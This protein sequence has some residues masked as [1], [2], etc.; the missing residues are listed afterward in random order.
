MDQEFS[1]GTWI[2]KRRTILGLSREAVAGQ[3]GYSIAMLR[4]IE[5]DERRPSEKAAALLAKALAIPPEQVDGFLKVA[6]QEAAIDHLERPVAEEPFPWQSVSKPRTNLPLPPTLFVGREKELANLNDLLQDPSCRLVTL[7]GLAGIGKTRLAIQAAHSQRAHFE[8]GVFFVSLSPLTSP[9]MIAA[10]ISNAMGLELHGSA[11]PEEH[12]LVNLQEKHILLVLDNFEHL[13]DGSGLLSKIVLEALHTRILVTSRERLNL[14]GEWIFDVPGLPYPASPEETRLEHVQAYESVQLFLQSATRVHP[15]FTL[16]ETNWKDVI[17]ICK[18]MEGMP[19]GI[20][21][22]AAWVRVLSCR[23]I[24]REIKKNLNFLK[25]SA[26]DIPERHRSLRAALDHSWALLSSQEKEVFS[27]LAVFRGGFRKEA[28]Q[29][30]A[31]ASLENITTLLDKSLLKRV[32]EERYD[33][34]ELVRQYTNAR[35][36]SN[37]Q[38]YARTRNRHSSY[39][40]ALLEKWA[41]SIRGP[42]Q[43]DILEQMEDEID[44]IRDAW[45]WMIAHHQAENIQRSLRS[46][47]NFHEIRARFWEGAALFGE[48]VVAFQS[49]EEA[50]SNRQTQ[51]SALLA[52]LQ[53]QQ[54]YFLAHLDQYEEAAQLLDQSASV[55]RASADQAAL[56]ETLTYFAYMKYRMGTFVDAEQHARESLH[57]NR[58]LDN[59]L[60]IVFGLIIL[61]YVALAKGKYEQAYTL[62][63]EGLSLCRDFLRDPHGTADCLITLTAAARRLG[64]YDQAKKWAEESLEISTTI[65]DRWSMAQTLRQLGLLSLELGET[66]RAEEF[67]R[68]SVAR[69]REVCDLTLEATALIGLGLA[70]GALG[71]AS[72]SKQYFLEALK[73]ARKT[74]SFVIALQALLGVASVEMRDGKAES[75]LELVTYIVNHASSRPEVVHRAEQLRSELISQLTVEQVESIQARAQSRTLEDLVQETL[76]VC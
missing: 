55:L 24:A 21:L 45:S 71:R 35:L 12:L 6:R 1:F 40:A 66:E 63:S 27:R 30:V 23:E 38:E 46:L 17:Y 75:A 59:R 36:Q 68:Q 13:I 29:E 8:D 22:A 58:M 74:K 48:A 70:T 4:K 61:S 37:T 53:A 2:K 72:T 41:E 32:G 65:N 14:Q 42:K 5:D 10:A 50:A 28:A 34:H 54:G 67:L 18:L 7:V 11:R 43:M 69:S 73:T 51:H 20:E 9:N 3:V 33:L 26:R 25:A 31:G 16:D 56:A 15:G 39:Y 60:G 52:R 47:W 62:S 49:Q 64:H 57:L 44:N 19:L 76:T